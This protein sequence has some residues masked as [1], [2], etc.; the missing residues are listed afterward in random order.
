M[1]DI[2]VIASPDKYV[3]NGVKKWNSS[4]IFAIL[5]SRLGLPSWEEIFSFAQW[6]KSAT[7]GEKIMSRL[8][9]ILI[10]RNHKH[11]QSTQLHTEKS[12]WI[13]I[14][15]IHSRSLGVRKCRQ[16]MQT[17]CSLQE[18]GR[19]GSQSRIIWGVKNKF[20]NSLQSLLEAGGWFGS[21]RLG[22]RRKLFIFCCK[23]LAM[24][25]VLL[26]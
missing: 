7:R 5:L 1:A 21:E 16:T 10:S 13:Y 18:N 2:I 20:S 12:E 3:K 11:I 19:L 15:Y 25:I 17:C 4:F 24:Q 6:V 14:A 22:G 9:C 23:L 26:G 8:V